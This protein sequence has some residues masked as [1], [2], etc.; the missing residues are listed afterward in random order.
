MAKIFQAVMG[1]L[2]PKENLCEKQCR[3]RLPSPQ[4]LQ[5]KIILKGSFKHSKQ[6]VSYVTSYELSLT[7]S[8]FLYRLVGKRQYVI[9]III[10]YNC[11]I[12][13]FISS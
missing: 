2:L 7:P 10:V 6:A 9:S 11:L 4:E 13:T 8:L 1:D 3:T 12:S 5:G